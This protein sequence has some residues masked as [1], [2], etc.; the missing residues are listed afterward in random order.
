MAARDVAIYMPYTASIYDPRRRRAG[1]A[2]RQMVM[3]ARSL[4]RRGVRTALITYPVRDAVVE[5][6]EPDLLSRPLGRHK[7]LGRAVEPALT[8][9]AMAR[10]DARAYIFRGASA[11]VGPGA[12]FCRATGRRLIFSGANDSDFTLTGFGGSRSRAQL[13]AA[14]VRT[15]AAIVVQSG[16]QTRLAGE[17]FPGIRV[18]EIPSFVEQQPAATGR[19]EAFLWA[20]RLVDYKRPL[21]YVEL[22]RAIPEARFR[23]VAVPTVGDT[24]DELQAELRRRAAGVANL[25]L[26]PPCPHAR[27]LELLDTTV[28]VVNTS[29]TE[30]MPNVWLEGW[31]RGVPALSLQFD[32]DRRVRDRGIGLAAAGDW[33]SFV[34]GARQLWETR[35]RRGEM[36]VAAQRYVAETHGPEPVAGAWEA[37]LSDLA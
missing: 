12:A 11:V 19:P 3:L 28:A 34:A 27:L 16:D 4:T 24:T 20:A 17:T 35:H 25:E 36:G 1:G 26:L 7:L 31:A 13:F 33:E 9:Q 6:V 29:V 15:A 37:L 32:P 14:G 5:E 8:W 21:E 22:A 2:E 18:T 30:G 10:A 23:M